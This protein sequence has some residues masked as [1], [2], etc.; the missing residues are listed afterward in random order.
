MKIAIVGAAG[1]IGRLTVSAA[2]QAGHAVLAVARSGSP[3]SGSSPSNSV[4]WVR[5][6]IQ[7]PQDMLRALAGADAVIC[8]FGAPLTRDT[9]LRPPTMCEIGTRNILAA[10]RQ[11]GIARLVCLSAIGVGDSKGRGRWV[12]RNLVEPLLLRRIFV[13]RD[14]QEQLIRATTV[15]WSIVRPAELTSGPAGP[16]R[17]VQPDDHESPEPATIS[18]ASVAAFLVH[19]VVDGRCIGRSPII[20]H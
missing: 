1:Q 6:D 16:V 11:H 5:G 7:Q 18:R 19:E 12:F 13:D 8:T 2:E 15:R 17:I 4:Q 3:P 9:I 20:C 10:M 14:R